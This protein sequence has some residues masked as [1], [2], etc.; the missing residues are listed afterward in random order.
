MSCR[1]VNA[2]GIKNKQQTDKTE[3]LPFVV[4]LV[5]LAFFFHATQT[6]NCPTALAVQRAVATLAGSLI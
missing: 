5:F 1:V 2:R 3:L 6:Y 4:P